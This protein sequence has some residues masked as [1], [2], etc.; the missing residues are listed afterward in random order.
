MKGL[1]PLEVVVVGDPRYDL[2]TE[3]S[4]RRS[5]RGEGVTRREN[6]VA[7]GREARFG[8]IATA[9]AG[10]TGPRDGGGYG[11]RTRT[12]APLA[13]LVRGRHGGRGKEVK[14]HSR[15]VL[16]HLVHS[17]PGILDHGGIA[18]LTRRGVSQRTR[19]DVSRGEA[20]STQR[21]NQHRC[22]GDH[23]GY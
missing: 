9:A 11:I 3:Q 12:R 22:N 7:H 6:R 21:D 15:P 8:S 17:S 5:E 14:G 13:T 2:R 16:M 10:H 23:G 18:D 1:A 20:S 19:R 4:V